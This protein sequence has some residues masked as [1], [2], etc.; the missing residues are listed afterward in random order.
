MT[1]LLIS[2]EPKT[3]PV[4]KSIYL[5]GIIV[6]LHLIY[7]PILLLGLNTKQDEGATCHSTFPVSS[8]FIWK[9]LAL[10]LNFIV[11]LTIEIV[12][13]VQFH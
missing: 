12:R 4:M 8:L 9:D 13:H 5:K 11:L 10:L 2:M 6:A 3:I 1:A 7:V